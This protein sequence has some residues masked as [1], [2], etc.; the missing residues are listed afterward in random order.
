M[1]TGKRI[2]KTAVTGHVG[3]CSRPTA[4]DRRG[5]GEGRAARPRDVA[6]P[7]TWRRSST[8]HARGDT[9]RPTT[10]RPRALVGVATAAADAA[11]AGSPAPSRRRTS[12][13]RASRQLSSRPRRVRRQRCWLPPIA[14]DRTVLVVRTHPSTVRRVTSTLSTAYPDLVVVTMAERGR[15]D[16]SAPRAGPAHVRPEVRV[17]GPAP[18]APAEPTRGP[19][20]AF[21]SRAPPAARPPPRH[22]AEASSARM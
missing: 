11:V 12:R 10:S 18:A 13:G 7:P 1:G 5:D 9:R 15:R 6:V 3:A 20:M 14:A 21:F 16:G 8:S 2:G 22:L 4:T 19:T 17:I